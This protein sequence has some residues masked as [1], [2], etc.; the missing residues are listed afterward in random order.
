MDDDGLFFVGTA[1]TLLRFAGFT[2][3]ADPNSCAAGSGPTWAKGLWSR[4][5]VAGPRTA[6]ARAGRSS[7]LCTS[8]GPS[9]SRSVRSRR[10]SWASGKSWTPRR[11]RAPGSPCRC[12]QLAICGAATLIAEISTRGA[13]VAD[14]VHQPGRLEHEQ[15]GLLDP[16]PA[17]R[18]SSP[19]RR[20]ARRAACR[21][22]PGTRPLAHQLQRPLGHADR[23]HAV[24]DPARARAAPARSRKPSPSPSRT[25]AA[26]TRTSS[27]RPPRGRRARR[28]RTRRRT[29]GGRPSRPGCRGGPGSSI[30]RRYGAAAGSVT[31]ITMRIRSPALIAPVDHHLRPFST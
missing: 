8:S 5:S 29:A 12:T 31:P 28:R 13:L 2:V 15:P 1:T 25:L 21:T 4:R 19:A 3:L 20:P 7:R 10:H 9:A 17:T 26:G 14:R 23:P 18:R 30:C 16:D 11:R 27:K 22:R 6:R 24:V